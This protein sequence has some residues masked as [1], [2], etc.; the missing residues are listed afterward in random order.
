VYWSNECERKEVGAHSVIHYWIAHTW[1]VPLTKGSTVHKHVKNWLKRIP[2]ASHHDRLV[3]QSL[4]DDLSAA[5][6]GTDMSIPSSTIS[7]CE[8]LAKQFPDIRI[9]LDEHMRDNG[10]LLPHVFFGDVTRW[11]LDDRSDRVRLVE[12]LDLNISSGNSDIENLIAVS[13]VENLETQKELELATTNANA[14][15]IRDEWLRQHNR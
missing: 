14:S 1:Y 9:L 13:F 8:D 12:C 10:E 7:F 3:T 4:L 6:R 5:L 2:D 11:V 15:R